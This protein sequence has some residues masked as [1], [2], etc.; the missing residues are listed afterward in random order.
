[1]K[2][3]KTK[4]YLEFHPTDVGLV[5]PAGSHIHAFFRVEKIG[6]GVGIKSVEDDPEAS[7]NDIF[8]THADI[9][10]LAEERGLVTVHVF[11]C[12]SSLIAEI[13]FV[14]SLGREADAVVES[15]IG[16]HHPSFH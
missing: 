4:T 14:R 15:E 10:G 12:F 2:R 8:S 13:I 5:L 7:G 16:R 1:M 6:K 9:A 11:L 3:L